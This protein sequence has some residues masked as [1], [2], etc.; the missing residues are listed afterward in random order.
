MVISFFAPTV[1][2]AAVI[3]FTGPYDVSNWTLLSDPAGGNGSVNTSSAPASVTITGS[4]NGFAIGF[5][6]NVNTD[7]TVVA[8]G[9]GVV[10]FNWSY[11][12]TDVANY[13][14]FGYLRNGSFTLLANNASQGS[15]FTQFSVVQGDTFGFRVYST[16]NIFGPGVATI[17]SFDAPVPEPTSM[18]IFG[19]GALGMAFRAHRRRSS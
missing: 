13:D 10:S 18:A 14:G 1:A 2:Q 5:V 4:G 17:S 19:L 6:G 3:G 11:S 8:A 16:D 12:S 9:T 15:G 7:Y